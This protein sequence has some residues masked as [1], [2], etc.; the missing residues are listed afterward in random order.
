MPEALEYWDPNEWEEH[1]RGLLCDRHGPLEVQAV[2]ARDKGDWGIDYYCLSASAVYQCHAVQ[3]PCVVADRATKQSSKITGDL[4]KFCRNKKPLSKLFGSTQISRWALVV[5]L[6]DSSSVNLHLSKKTAEVRAAKLPYAAPDFQAIV[7][8]PK[9]FDSDSVHALEARRLVRQIMANQANSIERA[10]WAAK[11]ISLLENLQTKLAKRAPTSIPLEDGTDQ[12]IGWFLNG[13]NLLEVLRTRAPPVHDQVLSAISRR[14][15]MLELTGPTTSASPESALR[16]EITG[17]K[18]ELRKVAPN[19]SEEN[20]H[21]LTMGALA[22]WLLR[23]PL[24]FPP[25]G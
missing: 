19:F 17:L 25:Y 7:Q 6:H 23:C 1:V 16:S 14:L 11:E 13:Q 9:S 15:E 3:E 5:P 18:E 12:A 4:D 20:V 24:D 22:E 10:A 21:T 8:C 2:P